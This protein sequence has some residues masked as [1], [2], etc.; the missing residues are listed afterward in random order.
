MS[1]ET[2]KRMFRELQPL[3]QAGY[4]GNTGALLVVYAVEGF[5]RRLSAPV[6]AGACPARFHLESSPIESMPPPSREKPLS[7]GAVQGSKSVGVL[8]DGRADVRTVPVALRRWQ[9]RE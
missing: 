4:G 6:Y 8:V 1:D 9:R 5:L 2:A 3:A 7:P